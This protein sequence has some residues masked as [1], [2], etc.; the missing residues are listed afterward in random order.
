MLS[1]KKIYTTWKDKLFNIHTMTTL[2]QEIWKCIST[3]GEHE[4]CIYI[5]YFFLST[6]LFNIYLN[7]NNSTVCQLNFFIFLFFIYKSHLILSSFCA[8]YF[9]SVRVP[10]D[11]LFIYLFLFLMW[12]CTERQCHWLSLLLKNEIEIYFTSIVTLNYL[13]TTVI[14]I[15]WNI[16]ISNEIN[17]VRICFIKF[18]IYKF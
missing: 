1:T 15:N 10:S 13:E 18:Y 2:C 3:V 8:F 4:N 12:T 17:R 9:F 6:E 7:K 11:I 5:S 16:K 14:M